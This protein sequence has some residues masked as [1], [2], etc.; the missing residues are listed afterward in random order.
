VCPRNSF[1]PPALTDLSYDMTDRRLTTDSRVTR[2]QERR[3]KRKLTLKRLKNKSTMMAVLWIVAIAMMIVFASGF[4]APQLTRHNSRVRFTTHLNSKN[5]K[6]DPSSLPDVV[7]GLVSFALNRAS[8]TLAN[9][10]RLVD[11][12]DSELNS[13]PS[14]EEYVKHSG[15]DGTTG[16]S[17][18]GLVDSVIDR[19]KST[20]LVSN[21]NLLEQR[22]NYPPKPIDIERY[23]EN[24]AILNTAL[25]HLLWSQVLRPNVD[26]AI[27]ATC[28]NGFDSVEIAKMLFDGEFQS[29]SQLLCIDI[30]QQAFENT[31]STLQQE[32]GP[33]FVEQYAQV[34][35][36]SHAPLPRPNDTSSVGLVVYNL[37]WLPKSGN[38]ECITTIHSTIASMVDAFLLVRILGMIS[39]VTYPKTG[40]REDIAVRALLECMALLSSR[41]LTWQE[42]LNN[43]ES[44]EGSNADIKELVQKAMERV[45]R[46]G[47]PQQTWRVSEHKKLGME[48]APILLTA[49]RIK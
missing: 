28:G 30:Q 17:V 36:T 31:T 5:N 35:H 41:A 11:D 15:K 42:Y 39:V 40:P 13:N 38:K 2:K 27:D 24:P 12:D 22:K 7:D 47:A 48:R 29:Q 34:R 32:F 33:E 9:K 4:R 10:Q 16:S 26:S 45:I 18:T 46:L 37:G 23:G 6:K 14:E 20:L 8:S 21:Q 1:P 25:A 19:A 44:L 3:Q 49:I 43:N